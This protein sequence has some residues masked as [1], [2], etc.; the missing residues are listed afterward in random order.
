MLREKLGFLHVEVKN[1]FPYPQNIVSYCASD[2][3]ICMYILYYVYQNCWLNL[4]K[5]VISR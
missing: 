4:S 1:R 5:N 3:Y 2:V